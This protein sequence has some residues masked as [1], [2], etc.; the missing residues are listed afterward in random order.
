MPAWWR[1]RRGG[2]TGRREGPENAVEIGLEEGLAEPRPVAMGAGVQLRVAG[3]GE[4]RR[5]GGGLGSVAWPGWWAGEGRARC[6]EPK[7]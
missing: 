2:P 5:V 7:C 6:E 3:A 1:R 4:D